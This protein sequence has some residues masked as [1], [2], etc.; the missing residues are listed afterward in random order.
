ML[1]NSYIFV[2]L[3]LPLCLIGYFSL[4]HFKLEKL[5]QVFLFGMSL[6]FYGYF[7][8]SYLFI[9]L[10]SIGLNFLCY[11]LME[12][13]SKN[14]YRKIIMIAGVSINV[15]ILF[16]FKYFDFFIS[17]I[18]TVFK[19]SWPLQN[20]LLPLG[21]SFFTFQQ[22]SFIV[23]AYKKEVPKY[24]FINYACFVTFF[25][26]LIAGPIVMHQ[27]LIPQFMDQTK[28]TFQWDNL[29]RGIYIFVIGLAKKVLLADLLGNAVNCGFG[30]IDYLNSTDAIIIMLAY[31]LQIYFDFSGY[32]DMAMGIARM[33]NIDLPL[34]FNSPYKAKNIA[35]FWDRWHMTLTQFLTKY[36]YIPLGG[37]R[38]SVIRT[39]I[40]VFLVFLISGFWHGANWTFV[41]WGVCHGILMIFTKVFKKYLDKIPAFIN[42][43]FT[44][45]FINIS[46]LLFR[47]DSITD[48]LKIITI[49]FDGRFERINASIATSVHT[50]ESTLI[51]KL[52]SPVIKINMTVDFAE[53]FILLALVIGLIILG[54][55]RNS[56]EL[57]QSFKPTFSKLLIT[58]ILFIWCTLS[59]AGVS[60]FLYFNF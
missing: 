48:A 19:T 31:T 14:I 43:I 33:F 49:G 16:Y 22:I 44:F 59:F 23:D 11:K 6:W 30:A 15:G 51:S 3:F 46:W 52:L 58:F 20:I 42:W 53:W 13:S 41:L 18:N 40:N 5:A 45:I 32:C 60:T 50:S 55:K 54:F 57:M 37:S 28:K 36:I 12:K 2:L 17:N 29:S 7:N 27:K 56:Y 4:N 24:S 26:Q 9:I 34:N 21:I 35:E 8:P 10:A 25:P 38:K 1:F 39:Y 47:A